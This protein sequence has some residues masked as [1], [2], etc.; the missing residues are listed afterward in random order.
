VTRLPNRDAQLGRCRNLDSRLAIVFLGLLL[1]V[2]LAL[3]AVQEHA[4]APT[5][6]S[7]GPP[8]KFVD[9]TARAAVNF[10][11][12]SSHTSKKYLPETMG[13]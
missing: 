12:Q 1:A 8:G 5:A 13:A 3:A 2:P 6:S 10:R 7:S 9:I 11:Y 4:S